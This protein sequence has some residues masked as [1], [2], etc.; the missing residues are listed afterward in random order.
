MEK[1]EKLYLDFS[2]DFDGDIECIDDVVKNG[3]EITDDVSESDFTEFI[4]N[5]KNVDGFMV[6][7]HRTQ[8]RIWM[9]EDNT[10]DVHF[11]YFNEPED[12][13]FEDFELNNIPSIEVSI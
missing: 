8:V 11:R 1:N 12:S 4:E 13:E 10:M 6:S 2:L 7:D 5:L 3:E 9:Y